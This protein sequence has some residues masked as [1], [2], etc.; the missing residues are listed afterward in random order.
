MNFI[1]FKSN[2]FNKAFTLIEVLIYSSIT[3][4]VLGG[5]LSYVFLVSSVRNK[6]YIREEVQYNLRAALNFITKKIRS[7]DTIIMPTKGSSS[8]ILEIVSGSASS[9]FSLANGRI[10]LTEN[11]SS[12]PITSG[13]IYVSEINFSN[14]SKYGQK[15]NIVINLKAQNQPQVDSIDYKYS[16]K[17]N[18]SAQKRK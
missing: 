18:T 11:S 7:A 8:P 6:N 15:D 1:M 10:F 12:T 3:A 17:L 9:T 4:L 16:L 5:L 2:K 13:D 14:L